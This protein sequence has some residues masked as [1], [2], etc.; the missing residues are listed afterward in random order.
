M[1]ITLKGGVVREFADSMTAGDI[2]KEISMGLY[3]AACGA[4][5]DGQVVDLRTAVN[6]D[7][8]LSILTFDDA[9]GKKIYWHTLSHV[10]AQAVKRVRADVKLG[11]GPAVDNGFFYDFDTPVP[12]N[13]DDLAKLEDEMK[14]IIKEDL[15]IERFELDADEAVKLMEERG[16]TYKIELINEHAE[17]GDKLSFYRQGEFVDLCAGPHLMSTG[18]L[19]AVKLTQC[20]GAYWRGDAQNAQMNR[21]YGT[22]FPKQS[23]LDEYIAAV[24]EAK[25]RDHNLIGRQLNY[26]TTNDMVGQGLPL[27]MPKGARVVQ[28]LQ[29]FVE[30]EEERRGYL[31]TKTPMMAKSDLYKASGH[32][33]HYKDGMFVL[34]D[35]EQDD[36]LF[37]LRPMT[38]PF[39]FCIY[40]NELHSYRDLPIRYGETSTLFR[41]ESSGEMHGLIRVRQFT[42]SEGHLVVT[43]EQLADEFK[44]VLDLINF[45]MSTLGIAEDVSYRFSKRDPQNKEKYI[46]SDEAWD[47]IERKMKDILIAFDVPHTEEEGEAAF[48]GP[49]LDIQMKNVHGKEDTIITV[50]I[51]FSLAERFNMVYIDSEGNKKH[52]YIIH[53]TS[54]GCYERTLAMLIEKFAGAMPLWLSPV[55][56]VILPISE[57]QHDKAFAVAEELKNAGLRVNV[58]D[59]NE[60]IGYKIREAQL[61]K[62]PY[63]LV[64]GDKELDEGTLSVRSRKHGDM[65]TMSAAEFVKMAQEEIRTK[66]L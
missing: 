33:S 62:T 64:I 36:E 59:R 22:G 61:E 5:I 35:E 46:G 45:M 13:H 25:K 4:V 8:E 63:M 60:K 37:A 34:G 23:E 20:T 10:L 54:V 32:W 1:N 51:D 49:K 41:N 2:A 65:G 66:A 9:E 30:D 53:R 19:K 39:Q 55:Q 28:L 11:V 24:E 18:L 31:L 42:I 3:K 15:P 40:N 6:G 26:F 47:D 44:G 12:F 14:K 21:V 57:R 27:L 50:Q 7:C 52:P 16:E 58:D 38:C 48:Y 56:A 43:P 29:R 17:K